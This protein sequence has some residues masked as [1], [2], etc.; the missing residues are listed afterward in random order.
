MDIINQ[1]NKQFSFVT[2]IL[3]CLLSYLIYTSTLVL[4]TRKT[5]PK[6]RKFLQILSKEILN[7]SFFQWQRHELGRDHLIINKKLFSFFRFLT[8]WGWI[9]WSQKFHVEIL[10]LYLANQ[11]NNPTL[12]LKDDRIVCCWCN[13]GGNFFNVIL[14]EMVTDWIVS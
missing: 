12:L 10:K 6:I 2:S 3:S 1:P 14:L 7:N 13:G 11:I 4:T 9:G 8:L 5:F